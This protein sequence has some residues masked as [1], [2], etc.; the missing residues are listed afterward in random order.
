[1]YLKGGQNFNISGNAA[2]FRME[3]TITG[4]AKANND[5]L[6]HTQKY[7]QEYTQ[8]VD[9]QSYLEKDEA[10]FITELKKIQSDLEKNIDAVAEKTKADQEVVSWKKNDVRTGI[11][12]VI[13]QYQMFQ[14]QMGGNPS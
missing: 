14:K 5:F 8:K 11:L 10:G 6:Q 2:T 13:P 4:D 12:S 9:M 7:M 3:Y 1:L